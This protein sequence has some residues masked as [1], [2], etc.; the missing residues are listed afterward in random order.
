MSGCVNGTCRQS[1]ERTSAVCLSSSFAFVV[2]VFPSTITR[3]DELITTNASST[4]LTVERS[5]RKPFSRYQEDQN[6]M[7]GYNDLDLFNALNAFNASNVPNT[8][9]APN[10]ASSAPASNAPPAPPA[11][12]GPR[13]R[14]RQWTIHEDIALCALAV[15][16]KGRTW[17]QI[18]AAFERE[19]GQP[20]KIN[21][22]SS[23]FCRDI[24]PR[25]VKPHPRAWIRPALERWQAGE[26][27]PNLSWL[28]NSATEILARAEAAN[29]NERAVVNN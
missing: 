25:A 14:P 24:K 21:D 3:F 22:L 9:N 18:R 2:I 23:R 4:V 27:D 16:R 20:R 29:A 1:E 10:D 5:S 11:P 19:T 8:P 13:A 28:Y 15:C 6:K 26:R 17:K 12:R 7:S